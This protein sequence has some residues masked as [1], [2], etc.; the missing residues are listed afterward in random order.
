VANYICVIG[1]MSPTDGGEYGILLTATAVLLDEND[2]PVIPGGEAEGSAIMMLNSN[3]PVEG[4]DTQS[5]FERKISA[6][7]FGWHSQ[8]DPENDTVTYRHM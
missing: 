2:T 1:A 5:D 6:Q 3:E 4:S 7:V 8:L